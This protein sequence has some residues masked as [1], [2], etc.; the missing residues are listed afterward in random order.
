MIL[1]EYAIKAIA[2]LIV[3]TI[4]EF[5]KALASTMQG[6]NRPRLDKRLTLNPLSHFEPIGFILFIF[7]GYG[8]GKPVEINTGGY[9]QRKRGIII[10]YLSPILVS[11][12][13]SILMRLV[14]FIFG[15]AMAS[16][17]KAILTL[18]QLFMYNLGLKFAAIAVF[19][20]IPIYPMCGSWIIRTMLK[21]NQVIK[22]AQSEK[23][24]QL[25]FMFLL[26][27]GFITPMLNFVV[28]IIF[29]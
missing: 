27:L 8:W 17:Q 7:T 23:I 29:R 4:F 2:I 18:L 25:I 26:F 1:I 11:V 24:F 6:D 5:T 28:F 22:F 3:I 19:N 21:P 12:V 10:T 16:S 20:L 13:I 14:L 9:N 15:E